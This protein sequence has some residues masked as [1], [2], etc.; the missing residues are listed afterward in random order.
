MGKTSHTKDRGGVH[1]FD[2][3][4]SDPRLR[5][6]N[7]VAVATYSSSGYVIRE[8]PITCESAAWRRSTDI[9]ESW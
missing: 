2:T 1:L 6:P 3:D 5:A 9:A 4:A 7:V 8:A